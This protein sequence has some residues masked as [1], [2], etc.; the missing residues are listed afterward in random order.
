[1]HHRQQTLLRRFQA[2]LFAP[3]CGIKTLT[4][5]DTHAHPLPTLVGRGYH[6][7][8]L[9]P[10]LVPGQP[11]PL[12]SV[13]G[14]MLA[15]W[16]RWSMHQGT[17]TMLGRIMAGSQAVIAHEAAGDAVC[18]PYYPPDL[19][20][21]QLIVAYCQPVAVAT[22]NALFVIDRAVNAVA[23]AQAFDAQGLGLRCRL[24]DNEHAGLASFTATA[25]ATLQDGAKV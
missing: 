24:D 25:V 8:T 3:L 19:H 6:S 1:V 14:H 4:G 12:T 13:D 21:S 23:L 18:G 11:A 16:S 7:S 17:I 20:L 22:G 15:Y 9:L 10:A 5:V 2:L